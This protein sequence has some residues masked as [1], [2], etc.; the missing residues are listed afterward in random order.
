MR[1]DNLSSAGLLLLTS[2]VAAVPLGC[3]GSGTPEGASPAA[4]GSAAAAGSGA[5]ANAPAGGAEA[6]AKPEGAPQTKGIQVTIKDFQ[7]FHPY[8]PERAMPSV[9]DNGSFSTRESSPAYGLGIIVEAE[10]TTGEVLHGVWFE[11]SLRFI[12]GDHE[13][14]CKFS[15]D[16]VGDYYNTS[17]SLHYNTVPADAKADPN[18]GEKPTAW[19]N[20]NSSLTESVWRPGE[21]I[22]LFSR[23]NECDSLV[24]ADMPPSQIKGRLLV[25]A[26]RRFIKTVGSEFDSSEFELALLGDQVRII[27]RATRNVVTLPIK[28]NVFEMVALGSGDQPKDGTYVPLSHLELRSSIRYSR[29]DIIE[30]PPVEFDLPPPV[31]T[32]QMVKM[33]SGEMVHASGNVLVYKKDDKVVYQDMAKAKMHLLELTREDVPASTPAVN[34]AKNEL[35]GQVKGIELVH[36]TDDTA[37]S[38]GQR[39]LAV[40]WTM[41]LQGD[42]IDKRLR[43]PFD[44]ASSEL[45]KAVQELNGVDSG[46]AAAVANAKANEAKAR[47]AKSAAETKYKSGLKSEREKLAKAFPCGDVKLATNR[48]TK[49]PSNSKAAVEACK[50]IITG[51]D[52][53]VTITY[54]LDRYEIPVALV[55]SLGGE[56]TWNSIASAPLLKLDA[57]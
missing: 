18:T 57:R 46:D 47:A 5:P 27:D 20:E 1:R 12:N 35:T 44:I 11:G 16:S 23:K 38:K 41:H 24:L 54:T 15:P 52:A 19:R 28:D 30:S 2:L 45:D 9:R 55:Y 56:F 42:D 25:R 22:R 50:A 33:P 32:L 13:V 48:G 8:S 53:E 10:N 49:G 4:S 37:L 36:F 26:N 14:S 29:A 17:F 31:M 21:K 39:K 40:T 43:V 34:F 6:P 51:D 3:K 7:L